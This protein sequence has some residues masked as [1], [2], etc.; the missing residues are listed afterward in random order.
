ME[1]RSIAEVIIQLLEVIPEKEKNL[2]FELKEYYSS[3]WNKAPEILET[4]N[5]W[6]PVAN[7]LKS[8]IGNLDEEWKMRVHKIFT[9][10]K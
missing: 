3:L 7:I 4:S 8:N 6:V 5:Y 10:S 9:N 2:I 1:Y